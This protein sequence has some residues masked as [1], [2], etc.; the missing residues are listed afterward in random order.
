MRKAAAVKI[1]EE[2][3]AKLAERRKIIEQRV[4]QPKKLENLSESKG[5]KNFGLQHNNII[6]IYI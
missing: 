1:Q 2:T 3:D 4:G 6:Y 5:Y